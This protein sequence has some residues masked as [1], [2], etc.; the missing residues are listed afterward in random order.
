LGNHFDKPSDELSVSIG[1]AMITRGVQRDRL[2]HLCYI[3]KSENDTVGLMENA[4]LAMYD[5]KPLERNLM[6]AAKDGKVARKGL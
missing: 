2:T 6:K 5:V 4:F 3:G 1:E